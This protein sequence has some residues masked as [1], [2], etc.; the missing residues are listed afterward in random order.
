MACRQ[1]NTG[2]N[3]ASPHL[4]ACASP[5]SPFGCNELVFSA[6][7]TSLNPD[8]FAA[9]EIITYAA[10]EIRIGR[11]NR[12]TVAGHTETIRNGDQDLYSTLYHFIKQASMTVYSTHI[13]VSFFSGRP[14]GRIAL[15]LPSRPLPPLPLAG[16]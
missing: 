8:T 1:N 9:D 2:E 11:R 6:Y 10:D 7:R 5:V 4:S 16:A 15:P 14:V 3:A 12:G 13:G